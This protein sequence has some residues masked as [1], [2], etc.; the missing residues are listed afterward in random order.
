[1]IKRRQLKNPKTK[2]RR[3]TKKRRK[4]KKEQK[5]TSQE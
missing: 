4:G 2:S 3:R 5:R 1:M